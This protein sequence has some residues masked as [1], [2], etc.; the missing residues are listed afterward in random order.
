MGAVTETD[1]ADKERPNYNNGGAE[2]KDV[3]PFEYDRGYGPRPA[4][5]V[6]N[7][8]GLPIGV[9]VRCYVGVKDGTATEV[10]GI[11]STT[12]STFSFTHNL[13]GQTGFIRV[14]D[15]AYKIVAFDYTYQS[16]DTEILIQPDQDPWFKNP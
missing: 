8:T 6:V 10:A 14:I 4:S 9:E 7:V 15:E 5:Y 3:G 11:E 1:I 13:G 2:Y 12:S 16:E